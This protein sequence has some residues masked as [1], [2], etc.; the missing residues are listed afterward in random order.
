MGGG[1]KN[2]GKDSVI[3]ISPHIKLTQVVENYRFGS[4][5]LF[6]L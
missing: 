2:L 4:Q 1:Q 3:W 5:Q 6:F